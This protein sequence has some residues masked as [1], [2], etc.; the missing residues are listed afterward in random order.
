MYNV[1]NV[2]LVYGFLIGN[3]DIF[4]FLEQLVLLSYQLTLIY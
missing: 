3:K 1:D 4:L 2:K